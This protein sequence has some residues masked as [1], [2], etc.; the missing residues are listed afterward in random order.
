MEA[1]GLDPG[2]RMMRFDLEQLALFMQRPRKTTSTYAAT[3]GV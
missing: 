1:G 2:E 3:R